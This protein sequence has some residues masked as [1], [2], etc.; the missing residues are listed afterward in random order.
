MEVTTIGLDIAKNVFQVHGIDGPRGSWFG[1]SSGDGLAVLPGVP[2]ISEFVPGYEANGWV[3][4]GARRGTPT[5]VVERLNKELATIDAGS[6]IKARLLALGIAPSR[7]RNRG[8]DDDAGRVWSAHCD[9]GREVVQGNQIRRHQAVAE[10][11]NPNSRLAR[12]VKIVKKCNGPGTSANQCAGSRKRK[13]GITRTRTTAI[14][15]RSGTP[16]R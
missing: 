11:A 9:R 7:P 16:L 3:G 13:S 2:V 8:E 1:S 12:V 4:L 10:S 15:M 14:A 5:E 6:K